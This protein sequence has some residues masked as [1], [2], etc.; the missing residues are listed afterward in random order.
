M[1]SPF[2]FLLLVEFSKQ[3]YYL[4]MDFN[5]NSVNFNATAYPKE[6]RSDAI[7]LFVLVIV[8]AGLMMFFSDYFGSLVKEQ[9]AAYLEDETRQS[10]KFLDKIFLSSRLGI[11]NIALLYKKQMDSPEVDW[12]D[13][14]EMEDNS[15]FDYLRFVNLKGI[16]VDSKGEMHDVSDRD[17][18]RKGI[19][20]EYGTDIVLESRFNGESIL[21]A[22]APLFYK[23]EII[24][25]FTGIHGEAWLEELLLRSR[26][27]DETISFLCTPNGVVFA[28]SNKEFMGKNILQYY[29]NTVKLPDDV[30]EKVQESFSKGGNFGFS[31]R[32]E[33]GIESA[34][35][36]QNARKVWT[37]LKVYPP[38]TFARMAGRYNSAMIKMQII[39]ILI[40]G[41]YIIYLALTEMHSR[42][43]LRNTTQSILQSSSMDL[44]DSIAILSEYYYKVLK[45]NLLDGTFKVI[46]S[47]DFDFDNIST[48]DEWVRYFAEGGFIYE[49]DIDSFMKCF[50]RESILNQCKESDMHIIHRYRRVMDGSIRWVKMEIL[51]STEYTD[52]NPVVL[53]YILDINDDVAREMQLEAAYSAADKA[54]KAKSEFL[55]N[56][57]HEIRTPM[58]A[59]IGMTA[60]ASLHLGEKDY[61]SDCLQKITVSSNHLMDLIN[62]VL[63]MG[64]IESGKIELDE[65]SFSIK[66]TVDNVLVIAKPLVDGKKHT[67]TV[68]V[69]ALEH[70]DVIGDGKR[71]QQ[72][73]MNFISNAVKY[74]PEAGKIHLSLIEKES[75]KSGMACFE[76]TVEDNGIGM[77]EEYQSHIFEPFTRAEDDERVSK[78]QGTGLGMSITRTVIQKM[79][80]DIK[81]SSK[82]DEGSKFVFTV[83]LGIQKKNEA[84]D[85][86]GENK[87]SLKDFSDSDFSGRKVLLVDDIEL[88]REVTSEILKAAHL[89]VEFAENGEEAVEKIQTAS[90]GY[91]DIVFMDVQMPIMDGYE[92]TTKIRALDSEYAKKVP[93]IAMTANAFSDD[94]DR[95]IDA[96]MN[97]HI[98]KPLE[99]NRLLNTLKKYLKKPACSDAE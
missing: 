28:S 9:N 67:L 19:K 25:V 58:N 78:I 4:K 73:L 11:N 98:S 96:G 34:F 79:G 30:Y 83:Y 53:L 68:S 72:V 74:T 31:Y 51:K 52:D 16:A 95:A 71:L 66:E 70:R 45:L 5:K 1:H 42:K 87:L 23:E 84:S 49:D 12:K 27:D 3:W 41:L 38:S 86:D 26:L 69:G 82:I 33:E 13:F 10:E 60:I 50:N 44:A 39:S 56:M 92:A 40:F 80:G 36:I 8:I 43:I 47:T 48:I 81:V 97:G 76:F 20:G 75:A 22:Y 59:I 90:D 57:S 24:G 88:N 37:L 93:I 6:R 63:D 62:Q 18:F 32:L 14:K 15:L 99:F 55:S 21:V 7:I 2:L 94:I 91:F 89:D 46:K 61:I 77:S 29:K 65:E 85:G 17:Y 35:L 54:N 64:K